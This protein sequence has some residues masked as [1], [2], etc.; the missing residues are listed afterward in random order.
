MSADVDA[1]IVFNRERSP[2]ARCASESL[3]AVGFAQ[4]ESPTLT[5]ARVCLPRGEHRR[6][7]RGRRSLRP[8]LQTSGTL[9]KQGPAVAQAPRTK[10]GKS[11]KLTELLPKTRPR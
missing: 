2:A 6:A 1:T 8:R 5:G 10:Q 4:P 3:V 7:D 11:R 9:A